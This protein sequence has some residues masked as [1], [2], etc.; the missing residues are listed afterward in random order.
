MDLVKLEDDFINIYSTF[1]W[2]LYYN[3]S[4]GV[5]IFYSDDGKFAVAIRCV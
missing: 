1:L 3:L 4:E 5:F 2:N